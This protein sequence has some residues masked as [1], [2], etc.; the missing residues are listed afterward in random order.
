MFRLLPDTIRVRTPQEAVDAVAVLRT[1]RVLAFDTETT[2][3]SRTTDRAIIL[4]LSS[5][6]D[7]YV[8]FPEVLP[9]FKDLLENPELK[10]IAHNA[11][12]DQW[13]LLNSGIDLNRH[14]LRGH[15][16]VYDT[17]VM[18]ALLDSDAGHGLKELTKRYLGIEMVPFQSVFGS[19]LRKR[20]L[21]DVLLD[22]INEAKVVNYAGLD[23]YATFNLFKELRRQL[24]ATATTSA[25]YP[26]MWDYFVMTEVPFTKVLWSMEREGIRLHC[27][28]LERQGP[29]L[30][31]EILSIQ[32]WFGR[33]LQQ[34]Y[35]NLNSNDQM[36][37]LFFGYLE[38]APIS[39]TDGGAPQL[40][41]ASLKTWAAKGCVYS[42]NLLRYRDLDKKFSTY[43]VNLLRQVHGDGRIHCT[44]NQTGARCLVK[45]EPVL[46][47]RGYLPSEDVRVGDHVIAHTG[48][49]R[50]VIETSTHAPQPIYRVCLTNGLSLKT[51]GNH[52]Y[53]TGDGWAR[54]DSLRVGQAVTVHSDAEAWR[55]V[56]QW[57][58]FEVSSWGRVRNRVTGKVL[59]LQPKGRWGHLK[60]TLHRN[61]AQSRKDG[62]R[63][64]SVHRLV[65]QAFVGDS[66]QEVRHLNGVAWDNTLRN[67]QYG[68]SHE[69]R[70]DALRHGTMSQ[71][72]AGR[73]RLT[74]EDVAAIRAIPRSGRHGSPT[75][76]LNYETAAQI[77]ACF[78]GG[79]G[80]VAAR[81]AEYG[82]S[83]QAMHKL[84]R[85]ETWTQPTAEGGRSDEELALQ[86]GVSR[87][88]MRDIRTGKK[89]ESED[90]I[91]GARASFYEATVASVEV[92]PAETTYGLTV[93]IDHSHVTAGIVTH[94][95]GRLSSSDPNLQNQ[96]GYIRSAYIASP[97]YKLMARDYEQLEMRILAHMSGDPTLCNAILTGLDVHSSTAA[98]MFGVSYEA[99]QEARAKDDRIGEAKKNKQVIDEVLTE[100]D[101][102]LI[103]YRKI[104]KTIN[105]G[106]MYGQGANKLA[107]TVGV[108]IDKARELIDKYFK[109]FPAVTRYFEQAIKQAREVGYCETILKR[110]RGLPGL[111]SGLRSEQSEAERKVKNT[112]IQGTAS[113]IVKMAMIKIYEDP[114]ITASGTRMLIQV[115]DEI[116]FEMPEAVVN[117]KEL[118]ERIGQHMSHP[119]D[120][121]DLR[122]PL[123][124]AGKVGSTWYECK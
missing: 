68:T 89:W 66:D 36:A 32:K 112:P 72:R 20:S 120:S 47:S 5:G 10:L 67:L 43:T 55:G 106:L 4:S 100:R 124:T 110:R 31:A 6:A 39:Y 22:P 70:Q 59:A 97:G 18:H 25:D 85:G 15:Y 82:V 41:K 38:H 29:E 101:K 17:M 73:A 84:L 58:S 35:I 88:H 61:G 14:C 8:V 87:E 63:D 23:A 46:T 74:E 117:D 57:D 96:P 65:L 24:L 45:G 54:A 51:T 78:T 103:G 94:N 13:M 93:E 123:D 81:A 16:R 69:N 107:M 60:V 27:A 71:R 48:L 116:V 9:Y 104:A 19:D 86:Y 40:N 49:T 92:L 95:T 76:K 62:R 53:R 30:E 91:E 52:E 21:E 50:R 11:N 98:T 56:P 1:K 26:T 37:A 75:A 108:D 119:F 83:V 2:G 122:V 28:E 44:F 99:I 115:H 12:F 114:L 33:Q 102:E 113:E 111:S 80:E 34:L 90:Y 79:K 121:F 64:L 118:N 42:S 105:F 109:T 7:R 3:L 77:R